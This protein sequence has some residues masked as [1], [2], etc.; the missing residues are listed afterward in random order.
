[1]RDDDTTLA[2]RALEPQRPVDLSDALRPPYADRSRALS[3]WR[4]LTDVLVCQG[5]SQATP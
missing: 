3:P 4:R 2:R 5:G 1:M